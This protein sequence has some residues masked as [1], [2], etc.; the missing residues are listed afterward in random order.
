MVIAG[1]V[2]LLGLTLSFSEFQHAN[3]IKHS[4]EL[5]PGDTISR[6]EAISA[7]RSLSLKLNSFVQSQK[8]PIAFIALGCGLILFNAQARKPTT[9]P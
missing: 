9:P 7:M 2:W 6:T 1:I 4:Q 3:W 8:Y 5:S